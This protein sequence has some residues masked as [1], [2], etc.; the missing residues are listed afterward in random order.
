MPVNS[1]TLS[2]LIA[3]CLAGIALLGLATR[4]NSQA[5]EI[6]AAQS[7]PAVRSAAEAALRSQLDS[8]MTGVIFEAAALD[9]RLRLAACPARL[10]VN[11]T[12]PRGTQSRVMVRVACNGSVYWSV[13]V[14]VDIHRKTDVL[15]MRRAV[16]RGENV[17]AA[18][19][20]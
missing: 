1:L 6:P 5:A 19:V 11:A 18:D 12:L 8:S 9:S 13:N 17:T 20:L 3:P 7:L 10:S 15:V 4:A 14:P 2:R 16:G